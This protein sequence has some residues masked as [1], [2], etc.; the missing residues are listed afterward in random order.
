MFRLINW[1]AYLIL[2]IFVLGGVGLV[3]LMYCIVYLIIERR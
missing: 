1:L 2:S 3:I